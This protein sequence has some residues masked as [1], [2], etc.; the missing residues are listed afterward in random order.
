MSDIQTG[1][2]ILQKAEADLRGVVADAA[3]QGEYDAVV[4]LT[5]WARQ[6]SALAATE[7]AD[8][9]TGTREANADES[10]GSPAVKPA[11]GRSVA[12]RKKTAAEH[13][14]RKGGTQR[15][16]RS[17]ARPGYP[18]FVREEDKLVKIG[19]SKGKKTTYE[20]KVERK[21]LDAIVNQL[22]RVARDRRRF[23]VDD[24]G[25]VVSADGET[26]IPPYQVYLCIAW[27]RASGIIEQHGRAGYSMANTDELAH[28]V[29][30]AWNCLDER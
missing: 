13:R 30:Q 15:R 21:S 20:H 25:E 17:S 5:S 10:Q 22:A 18:R 26:E 23:A 24:L 4:L 12:S 28:V 27:L 9:Q 19:W 16:R 6:L 11:A 3:S 29:E 1:R 8:A 7:S 2:E 14:K